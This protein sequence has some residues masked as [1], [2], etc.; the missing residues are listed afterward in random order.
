VSLDDDIPPPGPDAIARLAELLGVGILIE[1]VEA[2]PPA[3]IVASGLLDGGRTRL[4]GSGPTEEDAWR[5][6]ARA[7]IAWK[8][9]DGRNVRFWWGA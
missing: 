8:R 6:L 7:A 5:D 3:R 4:E 9:E 2:G 1:S